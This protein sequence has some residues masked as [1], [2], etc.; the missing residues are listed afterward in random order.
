MSETEANVAPNVGSNATNVGSS[1]VGTQE[2]SPPKAPASQSQAPQTQASPEYFELKVNGKAMKLTKDEVIARAQMSDAA[3]SKFS[4]AAKIRKQV[5]RIINTA[6]SNPIEALMDPQ[7]GLTKDQIRE[8]FEKW[9]TQEFIEPETLTPD[10]KRAKEMERELERYK[11]QEKE[12]REKMEREEQDKLTT[13]QREYLQ[14]QII[15]ALEKSGLPK[16]KFFA[17]RMAFYMRENL[18][19]GWEAPIELIAS[20][21]KKERQA[22]MADL[23]ENA[24]VESLVSMFGEGIINKIRQHDL[25]QLREKRQFPSPQ[26]STTDGYGNAA[27]GEKISSTEVTKRLRE[28]R[29]GKR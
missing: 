8:A 7:L 26:G 11:N 15:D 17:Q 4:E 6:K 23:T 16:T 13:Q 20:Q 3:D 10:Q 1:N 29:M 22:M 19:K 12:M 27:S 21:V 28:M 24:D 9:Y 25:K 14:Q 5:E 18:L 2:S